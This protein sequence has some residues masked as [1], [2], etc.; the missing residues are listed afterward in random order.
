MIVYNEAEGGTVVFMPDK[1]PMLHPQSRR[2][3]AYRRMCVVAK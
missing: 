3:A 1:N 2:L